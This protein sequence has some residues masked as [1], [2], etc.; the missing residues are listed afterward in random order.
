MRIAYNF[1]LETDESETL[2]HFI[3]RRISEHEAKLGFLEVIEHRVDEN[4]LRQNREEMKFLQRLRKK[5]I[6]GQSIQP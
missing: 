5:V 3:D 2:E 4:E 1:V 6:G